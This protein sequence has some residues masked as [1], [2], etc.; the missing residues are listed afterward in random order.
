MI[1]LQVLACVYYDCISNTLLTPSPLHPSPFL[2][3]NWGVSNSR[4]VRPVW[5]LHKDRPHP[6]PL[7]PASRTPRLIYP[8]QCRHIS[9]ITPT[10]VQNMPRNSIEIQ[11]KL[12]GIKGNPTWYFCQYS[13]CFSLFFLLKSGFHF[14]TPKRTGPGYINTQRSPIFINT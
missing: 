3:E 2:G 9:Y 1:T 6:T 12:R 13:L 4:L 5:C 10:G 11:V 7:P 14:Q 8:T